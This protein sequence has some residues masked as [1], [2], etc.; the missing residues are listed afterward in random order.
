MHVDEMS[1]P[2]NVAEHEYSGECEYSGE[3]YLMETGS[4]FINLKL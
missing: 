2:I 4:T 3:F 1:V